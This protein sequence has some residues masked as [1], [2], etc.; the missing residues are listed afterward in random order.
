MTQVYGTFGPTGQ[1]HDTRVL[2]FDTPVSCP[3]LV[4]PHFPY[5]RVTH[6]GVRRDNSVRPCHGR[7]GL[8]M[9]DDVGRGIRVDRSHGLWRSGSCRR[10][11]LLGDR[12]ADRAG[13]D[14]VRH[15][16]CRSGGG[17]L[18]RGLHAALLRQQEPDAGVHLQPGHGHPGC[19]G[20]KRPC[21]PGVPRCS[22]PRRQNPSARLPLRSC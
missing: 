3:A 7:P 1:R 17:R 12:T 16:A 15:R 11:A 14:A 2:R 9:S 13:R 4:A 5:T 21:S 6:R 10:T 18:Q 20:W 8:W 19:E 22:T